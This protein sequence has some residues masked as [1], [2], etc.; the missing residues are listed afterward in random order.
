MGQSTEFMPMVCFGSSNATFSNCAVRLAGAS[1]EQPRQ[2]NHAA[3]VSALRIRTETVVAVPI[4]MMICGRIVG[5]R[6]GVRDEVAAE[7]GGIIDVDAQA[8][9]MPGPTTSG[10]KVPGICAPR[11]AW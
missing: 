4:S 8:G 5:C 9:L 7:L 3:A 1:C 6:D 10:V 2:Q 11:R